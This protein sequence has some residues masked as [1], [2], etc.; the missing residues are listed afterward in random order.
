MVNMENGIKIYVIDRPFYMA[1]ERVLG[2]ALRR[3]VLRNLAGTDY[4][5]ADCE[6]QAEGDDVC[7]I[8]TDMPLVTA[9]SIQKAVKTVTAQRLGRIG[10]GRGYVKRGGYTGKQKYCV[11]EREFLSVSNANLLK[12]VYNEA[13]RRRNEELRLNGVIITGRA[14]IDF[15]AAAERGA[16]IEGC[17]RIRGASTVKSGA[18]IDNSDVTDSLI[19]SGAGIVRSVVENSTVGA[20]VRIG[21]Y[22]HLKNNVRI[23]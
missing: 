6:E 8:Y 11:K 19:E 18:L 12:I 20:G 14:E 5:L 1:E 13:V 2:L 9:E 10:L 3:H 21:P 7:V 15:A 23:N 22:I 16:R 17:S 4:V